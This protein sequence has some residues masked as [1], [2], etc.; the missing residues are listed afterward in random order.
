MKYHGKTMEID[1]FKIYIK[2]DDIYNKIINHDK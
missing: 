1:I 2:E